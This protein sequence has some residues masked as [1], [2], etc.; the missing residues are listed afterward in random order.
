MTTAV[1]S[2]PRHIG[3]SDMATGKVS[4]D[5]RPA[6]NLRFDA[7]MVALGV[8][9]MGGLFLDGS[10]HAHH[11]VDSFFTPWHAILYSGFGANAI[12]LLV[13][14]WRNQAKG[15]RL[16]Q[17]IPVG[18]ELSLAGALIFG[19]G[20]VIDL[21]WHSVFG[22]EVSTEALLSPSHL[23]LAL[24]V[25]LVVNGPFRAAWQHTGNVMT[26]WYKWLPMLLS[27]AFTFLLLTFFTFPMNPIYN[28]WASH[29]QNYGVSLED[30]VISGFPAIMLQ[31]ALFMGCLL[32]AIR[33][34]Q[35]PF[36]STTLLLTI[37]V[38]ALSAIY[39]R[40]AFLP[41]AIG[42]GVF[43]DVLIQVLKPS[44]KRP[45]AFRAFAFLVPVGL[46]LGYF[47]TLY[48]NGGVSWTV[49][50]WSGTIALTGVV[51]LF[52]SYLM[53]PAPGLAL[54]QPE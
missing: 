14:T 30:T 27:L 19:V 54:P 47:I 8:W 20:G 37:N 45:L 50:F 17:A 34:W 38:L 25:F 46:Y 43:A 6:S 41:M 32:I 13:A 2:L 51:G 12:A 22:I 29:Y 40:T 39:D 16:W 26:P 49:P 9:F 24:G 42:A 15:Y 33:R 35:L 44:L 52:L 28:V 48:F 53:L 21:I 11:A 5:V 7:L 23:V 31:T 3:N 18:Y 36:G 1:E 4:T 10:A